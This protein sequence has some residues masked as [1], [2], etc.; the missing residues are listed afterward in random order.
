MLLAIIG[1]AF[2]LL[3]AKFGTMAA[4]LAMPRTMPRA[5]E[6]GLDHRVLLFTL[7]VSVI[8]GIVMWWLRRP[9]GK[10]SAPSLTR[11]H[12]REVPMWLWAVAV[13]LALALPVFGWSLL[14]FVSG[15]EARPVP[16]AQIGS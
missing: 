1:G 7:F 2:G 12:V 4:L 14:A 15:V 13:A 10:L 11:D 9:K 16:I 3:L 6:I 8:S 5:E